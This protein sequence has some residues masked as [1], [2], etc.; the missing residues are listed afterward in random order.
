LLQCFHA[1][2][3]ISLRRGET[4]ARRA[5]IAQSTRQQP[6]AKRKS[7]ARAAAP[8]NASLLAAVRP[9]D[10]LLAAFPLAIAL[11]YFGADDLWV[12]V[13]S[14]IAI[15]PLAGLMGRATESLAATLGPALGGLLN[16]SFGNAA[17]LIIALA[18]LRS[19]PQMYPLVKASITGSIIGNV[20]LVLGLSITLGGLRFTYHNFNRTAASMGATLLTLA[21]VGLMIPTLYY[22]VFAAEAPSA[23]QLRTIEFLSEEIAFILAGVYVLSLVFSFVTHRQAFDSSAITPGKAAHVEK[24]EWTRGPALA[25]LAAATAGVA[26]MSELLVGSVEP[27][28]HALGMSSVFVGVIVVAI[29][30]NAAEHSTAVIVAMRDQMDLSVNIAVGS[31]MQIALFVAPVLVFASLAMGHEH[32]LDLHFT[33][34]E[35]VAVTISILVL[36]QVAQDGESH[37]LEGVMLLAVYAILALAFYHLGEIAPPAVPAPA[38]H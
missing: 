25:V 24:P 2:I 36:A 4:L 15:I 1:D 6:M 19:G 32:P 35:I 10:W 12:F 33:P 37:W 31:G 29:V 14:G 11:W 34:M 26:V 16:A 8:A 38:G 13:V 17:E 27:A 7:K 22:H 23:E 21:T 5:L 30:G 3:T 20:L 18:A 28:A 9:L